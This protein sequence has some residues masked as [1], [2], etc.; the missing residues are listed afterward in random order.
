MSDMIQQLIGD[1]A[2]WQ[3][4]LPW[5]LFV[6]LSAPII[7]VAWSLRVFPGW[8][9]IALV[10]TSLA[11]SV[12]SVFVQGVYFV[13]ILVDLCLLVIAAADLVWLYVFTRGGISVSREIPKTCSLGVPFTS[14]LQVEN[15]TTRL[16]RG[17]IRDDLPE[18]F[19]VKPAFHHFCLAPL[20]Q[21]KVERQ[22]TPSRRGA[23]EMNR[24]DLKIQSRWKLWNRYLTFAI[25]DA[26]NVYPNLRQLSDYSL[27][28]KT[29]RLSLIGVRKKRKIGHDNEFERLRDYTRDDSYR[30]IDWRSTAR[31]GR[32]TVK[33]FQSEQ[34]QRVIFLLDCGRMMV[35]ER[36]GV[37]LL[38]HALNS[39]LMMAHVALEQGDSVGLLCFSDKVH[40][41]IPPRSGKSQIQRLIHAGFDQFPRLVESRYDKAFLYLANH[42]K[43]RSMVILATNVIDEVNA[44]SVVDHLTHLRGPHLP[45][46]VLMRDRSIYDAVE[47]S[48]QG[49]DAV[50]RA[51]AA[52]D[53]LLWRDQVLRD[54]T[55][56]GVLVVDAFPDELSA[57]LVNKYLEVKAKHLL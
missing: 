14:L 2:Q 55:H 1:P 11:V 5:L 24:V 21:L 33:Q 16:L 40:C 54:L 37:S 56:R 53:V 10:G 28:A 49:D 35:N 6:L 43:R 38:D 45:V 26:V 3:V 29:D 51:A 36:D 20:D 50:F 41:F 30:H 27:L 22:L 9:W 47:A 19:K 4:S 39:V 18:G 46:G 34:S 13:A 31:R 23:F 15:R 12:V 42:C 57:P 7:F 32:L 25:S 44:E 8:P 48:D 52:A 17:I